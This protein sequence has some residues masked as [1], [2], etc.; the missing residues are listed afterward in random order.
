MIFTDVCTPILCLEANG[1]TE[2]RE[3]SFI[4]KAWNRIITFMKK[5]WQFFI[6]L[7]N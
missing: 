7:F 3:F 2:T 4:E 6:N 5:V 1:E